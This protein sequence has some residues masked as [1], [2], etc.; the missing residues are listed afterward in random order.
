M[1]DS[2]RLERRFYQLCAAVRN[3]Q[4]SRDLCA[5]VYTQITD[6]ETECN[7]LLTYDRARSKLA[8][9]DARNCLEGKWT[10]SMNSFLLPTAQQAPSTWRYTTTPPAAGWQL[11]GSDLSA[12]NT[13]LSGFGTVNTPGALVH[14]VWDTS[15]IWLVREFT[16]AAPPEHPPVLW[17][18]HD[19]TVEVYLNGVEACRVKNFTI[20]YE[21]FALTPEAAATLKVGTNTIAIHC[22]QTIGGQYIDAGLASW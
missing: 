17:M 9:G 8:P 13:G 3:L 14:T 16:L 21:D 1:A 6:V 7:G 22:H 11:P 4:A 18:H 10:W 20:D 12:W 2:T 5:A 15:D 19:E